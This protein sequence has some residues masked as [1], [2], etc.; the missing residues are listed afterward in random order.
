[1][2]DDTLSPTPADP[3]PASPPPASAD[4]DALARLPVPYAE[5]LRLARAGFDP[6]TIAERLG[7]PIESLAT[8]FTLAEAKLARFIGPPGPDEEAGPP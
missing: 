1:M 3:L 2:A 7:V 6:R 5:A 8:L 4:P